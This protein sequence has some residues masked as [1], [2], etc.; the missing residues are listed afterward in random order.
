MEYM[1][2]KDK[3]ANSHILY[4]AETGGGKSAS[5]VFD[6]MSTIAVYNPRVFILE[7]G[8]SFSLFCLL[9]ICA[10]YCNLNKSPQTTGSSN[11]LE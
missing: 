8:D 7:A 2:K 3:S 5:L 6:L 11:I 9:S 1:S 4:L 10:V